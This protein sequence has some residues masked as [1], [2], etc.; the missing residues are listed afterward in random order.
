MLF[1][2]AFRLLLDLY[3]KLLKQVAKHFL[4]LSQTFLINLWLAETVSSTEFSFAF[5]LQAILQ[6]IKNFA[7]H[8]SECHLLLP[9]VKVLFSFKP[10]QKATCDDSETQ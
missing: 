4:M 8:T 10:S 1:T 2:F 3:N 6:F 9:Y 7:F 5:A